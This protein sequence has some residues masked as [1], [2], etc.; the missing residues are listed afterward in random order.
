MIADLL[1]SVGITV[2]ALFALAVA[3]RLFLG[4]RYILRRVGIIGKLSGDGGPSLK[5][6][7]AGEGRGPRLQ[8]FGD[9]VHA[10]AEAKLRKRAS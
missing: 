7:G 9:I 4:V 1:F 10:F 3:I 8:S 2:A 5:P 6:G